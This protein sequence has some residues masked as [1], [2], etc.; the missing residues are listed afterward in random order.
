ME[1]EGS[2]VAYSLLGSVL[3]SDSHAENAERSGEDDGVAPF[4]YK[5]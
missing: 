1:S 4:L 3:W 5:A 2:V